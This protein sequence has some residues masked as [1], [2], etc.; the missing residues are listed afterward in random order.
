M[1]QACGY[2][3]PPKSQWGPVPTHTLNHPPCSQARSG[4][5]EEK[6]QQKE[7][8]ARRLAGDVE[9]R[10]ARIAGM[11]QRVRRME[12]VGAARVEKIFLKDLWSSGTTASCKERWL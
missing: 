4:E 1:G 8:K 6:L 9:E 3:E 5:Q 10:C 2:L 7:E 12:E 11:E